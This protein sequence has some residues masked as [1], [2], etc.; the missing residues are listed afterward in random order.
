M[1]YEFLL[2]LLALLETRWLFQFTTY[3]SPIEFKFHKSA[4][5]E[6]CF[7]GVVYSNNSF[8]WIIIKFTRS[9]KL[10]IQ[11]QIEKQKLLPLFREFLSNRTKLSSLYIGFG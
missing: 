2:F 11:F 6:N 8:A 9:N 3:N 1:K 5:N 10:H 7:T 4:F